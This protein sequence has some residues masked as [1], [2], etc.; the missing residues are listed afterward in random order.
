MVDHCERDCHLERKKKLGAVF[1][2]KATAKTH[3]IKI[4]LFLLYILMIVFAVYSELT[5]L[6]LMV[7]HRKIDCYFQGQPRLVC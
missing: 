4:W 1:K 2:V 7:D 5:K 3:I 6:S